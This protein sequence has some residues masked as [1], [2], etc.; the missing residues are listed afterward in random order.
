MKFVGHESFMNHSGITDNG[1]EREDVAAYL[2]GELTAE[3]LTSFET[4]LK[5]CAA[6]AVELRRQRQLLCTL[7][8]AFNESRAFDLPRD[9][10]CAGFDQFHCHDHSTSRPGNELDAVAYFCLGAIGHRICRNTA[11]HT[12]KHFIRQ[13]PAGK[14]DGCVHAH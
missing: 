2:D 7:D 12:D 13:R 10:F 5:S 1:C 8:V 3:E 4:H 14:S 11:E 6:C 9:F